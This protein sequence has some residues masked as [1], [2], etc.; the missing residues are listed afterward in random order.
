MGFDA[1]DRCLHKPVDKLSPEKLFDRRW[2]E[3]MQERVFARLRR[4]FADAGQVAR[5]D[6]CK[7]WLMGE[8]ADCS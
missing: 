6:E 5:F 4:E 2:A 1:E 8:K 3:T 7:P